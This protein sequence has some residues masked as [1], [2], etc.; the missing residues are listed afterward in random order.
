M[1]ANGRKRKRT[2]VSLDHEGES[3]TDQCK[4]KEII[5]S[6]YKQLFGSKERKGVS[7]SI[8]AWSEQ[9]RVTEEENK[10]ITRP[11]TI[12]E[13]EKVVMEM[14]DNTAPGPDGLSV[15]FYK[16]FW[17]TIR[18]EIEGMIRDF[19][20]NKLDI[21]RL[22]YG[23]ISLIPKVQEA[24]DIKQYR[25]I[26]VSNVILKIFTK[27]MVNRMTMLADNIISRTQSTFIKGRYIIDSAVI[28]HEV[29]HELRQD[30]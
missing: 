13:A 11:F 29:I 18:T 30:K 16:N 23:V 4:I 20:E 19:N 24:N 5:Y 26:C 21:A 7:L 14:K 27:M 6:Y 3:V 2:S 17:G 1:T 22:N 10:I 25:P 8:M 12:E 9:G 15:A 28:L